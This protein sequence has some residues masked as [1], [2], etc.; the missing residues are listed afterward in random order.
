MSDLNKCAPALEAYVAGPVMPSH[1]NVI[2]LHEEGATKGSRNKSELEAAGV[3]G[4]RALVYH[5]H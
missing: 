3:F 2:S 1:G 5:G 4:S